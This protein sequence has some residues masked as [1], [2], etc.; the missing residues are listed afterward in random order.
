M[1]DCQIPPN[2]L[3]TKSIRASDILQNRQCLIILFNN[4]NDIEYTNI[5]SLP[6]NFV[7][8]K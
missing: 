1:N 5:L 4:S 3:S 2:H 7:D 8:S 6:S